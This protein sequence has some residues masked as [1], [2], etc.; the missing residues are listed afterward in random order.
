MLEKFK[1]SL[2]DIF[3]FFI[4]G[5]LIVIICKYYGLVDKIEN[6]FGNSDIVNGVF[7]III[8]YTIGV[9]YEPISNNLFKYLDKVYKKFPWNK[10]LIKYKEEQDTVYKPRAEEIIKNKFNLS[11]SK[12]EIYQVAKLSVLQNGKPNTFMIFLSRYGFYRSLS[13]LT[14]INIFLYSF[15]EFDHTRFWISLIFVCCLLVLHLF[16]Y[17]R[18][19][20]FY[21]Y[22]GNEVY[23]NFI[24]NEH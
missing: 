7:Y 10:Y 19:K 1:F 22:A 21:F 9:I 24:I 20:E 6:I 18:A 2:W 16:L 17:N 23:R 3:T 11:D 15:I 12:M 5:V 8:T 4:T 14:F 13:T